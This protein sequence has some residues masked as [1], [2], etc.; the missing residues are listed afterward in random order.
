MRLSASTALWWNLGNTVCWWLFQSLVVAK[1]LKVHKFC[2]FKNLYCS[3]DG[4][5]LTQIINC[6]YQHTREV[7]KCFSFDSL[8]VFSAPFALKRVAKY[9]WKHLVFFNWTRYRGKLYWTIPKILCNIFHKKVEAYFPGARN[10]ENGTC[11]GKG[12]SKQK[13]TTIVHNKEVFLQRRLRKFVE[14]T[15]F[16]LR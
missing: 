7:E 1:V 10:S 9:I 14:S 2:K 13:W 11:E 6:R 3:S 4:N 16:T 12:F 15:H 5:V 8:I